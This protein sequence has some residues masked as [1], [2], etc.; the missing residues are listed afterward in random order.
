MAGWGERSIPKNKSSMLETK[1]DSLCRSYVSSFGEFLWNLPL[2]KATL[3]LD[4]LVLNGS[5]PV[6]F[7]CLSTASRPSKSS[8]LQDSKLI[9]KKIR[10]EI[11]LQEGDL[12][13]NPPIQNQLIQKKV[14]TFIE[15]YNIVT[16]FEEIALHS[17]VS[18]FSSKVGFKEFQKIKGIFFKTQKRRQCLEGME[19]G[20]LSR[21]KKK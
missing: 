7:V 17:V 12:D 8:N 14:D 9:E 21:C 1:F 20:K 10:L 5:I 18:C 6:G 19:A 2:R 16:P 13:C 3:I 11:S 15:N 4:I